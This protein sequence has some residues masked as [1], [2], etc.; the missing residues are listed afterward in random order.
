M[1]FEKR[2]VC[3]NGSKFIVNFIILPVLPPIST[4]TLAQVI[5]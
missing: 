2:D 5:S 3:Y 1:I 4:F